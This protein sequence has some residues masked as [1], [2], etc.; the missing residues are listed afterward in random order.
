MLVGFATWLT[1]AATTSAAIHP[2]TDRA[3]SAALAA[4]HSNQEIAH[5]LSLSSN[6]VHNHI[7]SIL[8]KLQL[9]NHIQAA[10]HAVRSDIS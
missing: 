8:A 5:E 9:D 7:T 3:D 6:T 10:V 1:D 2:R 4:F